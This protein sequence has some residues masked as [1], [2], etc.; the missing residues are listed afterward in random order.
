MS[1]SRR[2]WPGLIDPFP[3]VVSVSPAKKYGLM[4]S[5]GLLHTKSMPGAVPD[6]LHALSQFV[7]AQ[8][9]DVGILSSPFYRGHQPGKLDCLVLPHTLCYATRFPV[10]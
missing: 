5:S 6:T 3:L 8:H 10:I 1:G 2:S 7:L 4:H 9:C